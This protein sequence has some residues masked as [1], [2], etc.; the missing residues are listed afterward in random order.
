MNHEEERTVIEL[1][2]HS[3]AA[4]LAGD[5]QAYAAY[6]KAAETACEDSVDGPLAG[7]F[8]LIGA[9]ANETDVYALLESYQRAASLIPDTSCVLP[10]DAAFFPI[11]H[12][13]F[14]ACFRDL[15]GADAV[16]AALEA[17]EK[18]HCRLVDGTADTPTTWACQ[19]QLAYYRGMWD[20]AQNYSNRV[21]AC[22][23]D[24]SPN[25]AL[26][27]AVEITASVAKHQNNTELWQTA[28]ASMGRI[29]DGTL[30]VDNITYQAALL[31]QSMAL[32]SVGILDEVPLWVETGNLGVVPE[33]ENF[34]VAEGELFYT[35][36]PTALMARFEYLTY[37]GHASWAL[38]VA[39]VAQHLYRIQGMLI[40]DAYLDFLRAGC[41]RK[42]GRQES[43]QACIDAA[44]DRIAPD[45]LWT[46]AAE[47]APSFEE[48]LRTSLSRY[49]QEAVDR[50]FGQGK[51]TYWQHLRGFM[52]AY[53]E[54]NTTLLTTRER[55]VAHL[56]ADGLTNSQIAERLGMGERT[57]KYHLLNTYSKL[58]IDRR[59]K[60]RSALEE[61]STKQIAFWIGK[62]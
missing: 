49:G 15:G 47:F 42:L 58:G 61:A 10:K 51:S 48:G 25:L 20:E 43:M 39:D 26:L 40:Y 31:V 16:I 34:A 22:V 35:L 62:A 36:V 38:T 55:E 56:A 29:C 30:A 11:N 17:C 46:V 32:M 2:Q 4:Y 27:S 7:E 23:S 1:L 14:I 12:N 60:L 50:V 21:F 24:D 18:I 6:A 59:I 45:G 8:E 33:G 53:V 52:R 28:L 57:V 19:A 37:H 44:V 13:P 9:L 54:K 5:V 3:Y 41:W